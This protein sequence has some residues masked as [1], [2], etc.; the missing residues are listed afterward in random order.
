MKNSSGRPN[1][2]EFRVKESGGDAVSGPPEVLLYCLERTYLN[3]SK[4]VGDGDNVTRPVK[5]EVGCGFRMAKFSSLGVFLRRSKHQKCHQKLQILKSKPI[6][7]KTML[8]II[9][10]YVE[11]CKFYIC[12][13]S[14]L[15]C[16][17]HI[18]MV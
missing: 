2:I 1:Q 18:S 5:Q 17:A 7:L 9:K 11:N 14:K 15:F 13:C 3:N 16:M 4:M 12:S 6:S 8:R 10:L